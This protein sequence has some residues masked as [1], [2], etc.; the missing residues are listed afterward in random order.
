MKGNERKPLHFKQWETMTTDELM[1]IKQDLF[2]WREEIIN[3]KGPAFFQEAMTIL[4]AHIK[5]KSGI[6]C[7][8]NLNKI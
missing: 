4:N 6:I 7:V 1:E 3:I 5:A 8:D 2:S